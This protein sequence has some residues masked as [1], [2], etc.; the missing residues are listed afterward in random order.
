MASGMRSIT[1]GP[2]GALARSDVRN[3]AFR[4]G[5]RIDEQK[6]LL[7]SLF[8]ITGPRI[9]VDQMIKTLSAM[10]KRLDEEEHAIY[11]DAMEAAERRRHRWGKLI[12]RGRRTEDLNEYEMF[13]VSLLLHKALIEKTFATDEAD[14]RLRQGSKAAIDAKAFS[15]ETS[16]TVLSVRMRYLQHDVRSGDVKLPKALR[17]QVL[18]VRVPIDTWDED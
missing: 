3:V 16:S 7:S 4:L 1:I 11:V 10:K 17:K 8:R 18:A 12:G 2:V 13:Q 14:K 15:A 5:L 9:H 6:S